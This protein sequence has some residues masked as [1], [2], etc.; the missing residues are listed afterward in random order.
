MNCS[1]DHI[2]ATEDTSI[3]ET[4]GI[5]LSDVVDAAQAAEML[6]VTRQHVVHL[7]RTGRLPGKRLSATWVT[8]REAV[9]TYA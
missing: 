6:N 1:P 5:D 7:L 4:R 9:E 3:D 8:T 2:G